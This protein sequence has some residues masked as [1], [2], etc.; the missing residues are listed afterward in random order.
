M[1]LF[2]FGKLVGYNTSL[3]ARNFG[4]GLQIVKNTFSFPQNLLAGNSNDVRGSS[5][6]GTARLAPPGSRLH[7]MREPEPRGCMAVSKCLKGLFG[8]L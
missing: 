5:I 7:V 6:A 2:G 3:G 1:Y 8:M 4:M